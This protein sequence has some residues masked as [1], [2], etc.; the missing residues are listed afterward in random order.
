MNESKAARYQRVR[1]RATVSSLLAGGTALAILA[2]T[3]AARWL[4]DLAFHLVADL[5]P[6]PRLAG[7]L[8]VFVV[9]ATVWWEA[10]AFVAGLRAV[11]PESR[12]VE[13]I[14]VDDLLFLHAKAGVLTAMSAFAAAVLIVWATQIA[15]VAWWLVAGLGLAALWAVLLRFAPIVLSRMARVRP[16]R[17]SELRQALEALAR[18]VQVPVAGIDEWMVGPGASAIVAGVGRT[19]RVL[20]SSEVVRDWASDEIEVVVAHEL[21][22]HA[23]HDLWRTLGLNAAVL[24]VGL[25]VAHVVLLAWGS[26]LQVRGPDD[27]AALPLVALVAGLIW[28]VSTPIRHA[29]SRAQERRADRFALAATGASEAFRTAIRRLGAQHLAEEHPSRLTRW[30]HHAHP[31]MTERLAV[32]DEFAANRR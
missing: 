28:V 30:L 3:P 22:H 6:F 29:Q 25:A 32:A 9:L 24:A 2:L 10:V 27:L 13:S 12:S 21:A 4:R 19:R 26:R 15:G 8:A 1:R 17:R 7:A 5:P 31:S 23:H 14:T 20:V 16:I 11:R 18:R